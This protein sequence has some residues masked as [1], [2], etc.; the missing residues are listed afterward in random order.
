GPARPERGPISSSLVKAIKKASVVQKFYEIVLVHFDETI[1]LF[2]QIDTPF[3]FLFQEKCLFRYRL[4]QRLYV[5][6]R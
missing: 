1:A 4:G 3:C 2:R 5:A 6:F